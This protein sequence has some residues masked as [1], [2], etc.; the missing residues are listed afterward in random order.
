[1]HEP[2]I[3]AKL[4]V[5]LFGLLIASKAYRGYIRHGSSAMLYLAVGFTLI[6]IG[7]VIEGFLFEILQAEL[8]LAGAIQTTIA[9]GGMLVILYSL[10]G[11]HERHVPDEVELTEQ[12]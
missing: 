11:S 6:S 9:A 3:A 12:G 2:L 1:M 4:V 5:L 8:H 10:Y 7:T